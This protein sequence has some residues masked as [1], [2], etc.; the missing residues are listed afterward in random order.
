MKSIMTVHPSTIPKPQN[1]AEPD[2]RDFLYV[3]TAVEGAVGTGFTMRPLIAN[4]NPSADVLGFSTVEIDLA[5]IALGQ[6]I[7]FNWQGN[8]VFISH[9]TAAEIE[10]VRR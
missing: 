3:A 10:A 2:R 8:P 1:G 9:R 7:T 6:R 4:L 5:P